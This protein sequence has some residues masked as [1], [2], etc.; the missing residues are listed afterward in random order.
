MIKYVYAAHLTFVVPEKEYAQEVITTCIDIEKELVTSIDVAP[1]STQTAY[2][3]FQKDDLS[4]YLTEANT[5]GVMYKQQC[6]MN[7]SFDPELLPLLKSV[8]W[9]SL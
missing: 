1:F 4:F 6:C 5:F 2:C 8:D 7:I 3:L 9:E